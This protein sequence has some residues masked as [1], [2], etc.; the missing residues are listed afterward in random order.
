MYTVSYVGHFVSHRFGNEH[1]SGLL[2]G[3]HAIRNSSVLLEK[4]KK[5]LARNAT[6]LAENET[7]LMC[8][9]VVSYL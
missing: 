2:C 5:R 1:K 4:T 9:E 6:Y 3:I 7:R 8:R